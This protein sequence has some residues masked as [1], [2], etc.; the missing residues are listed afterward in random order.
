M[1]NPIRLF[2]FS[3]LSAGLAALIAS[4]AAAGFDKDAAKTFYEAEWRNDFQMVAY[5]ANRQREGAEELDRLRPGLDDTML[6]RLAVCESEWKGDMRMQA[7]CLEQQ[8]SARETLPA[9]T[10][11]L[12]EDATAIIRDLCAADWGTDFRMLHYCSERQAKA[13]KQLNN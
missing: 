3:V 5:C 4:A 2:L 13:W 6:E 11:G 9:A 1:I 12:P 7:Y 8:M 10:E